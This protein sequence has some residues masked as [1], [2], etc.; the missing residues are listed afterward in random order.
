MTRGDLKTSR[1]DSRTPF[2]ILAD[3]YQTGDARD[4]DL[5]RDYS[6]VT[7]GLAAVRW[8]QN[9]RAAIF[10]KPPLPEATDEELAAE[11]VDGM[12]VAIIPIAAWSSIRLAGLDCAVL[13]MAEHGAFA[14]L[15]PRI[16]RQLDGTLGHSGAS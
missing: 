16:T 5:W 12:L 9:L 13:V 7:R 15:N 10:G 1:A 4:R 14:S 8:S 6:R 11:D 3:Y 2:Q